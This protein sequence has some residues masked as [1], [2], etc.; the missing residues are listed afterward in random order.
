MTLSPQS[1]A[2]I[3]GLLQCSM[4]DAFITLAS[5]L[6]SIGIRFV[7][8][9]SAGGDVALIESGYEFLKRLVNHSIVECVNFYL[10]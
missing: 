8:D 9:A 3:A 1:V 4:V 5:M 2:S 10:I 6:K 7:F